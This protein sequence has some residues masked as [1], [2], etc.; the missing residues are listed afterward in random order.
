MVA[1]LSDPEIIMIKICGELVGVDSE[2]ARFS[3]TK[4]IIIIFYQD[5]TTT[6]VLTGKDRYFQQTA[7]YYEKNNLYFQHPLH[8]CFV[9]DSFSLSV[10][11]LEKDRYGRSFLYY[12]VIMENVLLKKKP[13]SA[14]KFMF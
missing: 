13:I 14:I 7:E 4:K 1:K 8:R 5:F 2:N 6:A 10:C 12:G 11:K 3:L 9:I